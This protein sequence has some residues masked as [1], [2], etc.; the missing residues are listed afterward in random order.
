MEDPEL[1]ITEDE[2]PEVEKIMQDSTLGPIASHKAAAMLYRSMQAVAT[3]RPFA[4]TADV[5]GMGASAEQYKGILDDPQK[6][7]GGR[8]EEIVNDFRNGRGHKWPVA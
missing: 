1:R 5:P 7:R 3:P 6:W 2:I 4:L 8:I